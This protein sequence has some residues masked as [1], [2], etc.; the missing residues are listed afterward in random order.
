MNSFECHLIDLCRCHSFHIVNGRCGFDHVRDYTFLS[1]MGQSVIDHFI[2]STNL[3]SHVQNFEV[4]DN[5]ISGHLLIVCSFDV[6]TDCINQ[7]VNC[8]PWDRCRWIDHSKASFV[9]NISSQLQKDIQGNP[10]TC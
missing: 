1:S 4:C 3:F 9:S 7:E 2:I 10:L 5:D 6:K 8:H